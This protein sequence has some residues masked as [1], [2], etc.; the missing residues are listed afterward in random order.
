MIQIRNLHKS[1][2]KLPVLCGINLDLNQP[3]I[4]AILGPNGSGKTTLIKSMLGMVLPSRGEILFKGQ[5]IHGQWA[6]RRHIDYLPQIAR[7]PDNLRVKELLHMIKDI[8]GTSPKAMESL[9]HLF[10]MEAYM[11]KR[12][13]NLSGG[14]RQKANLIQ[15]FMYDSPVVI[16]DE[17]TSGLDPIALLH[18]KELLLAE[19]A[20]GKMILITTHIM[21]FV[22]EMAD[23][24]IFLLD[25]NIH[26]RGSVPELKHTY[27]E[28]NLETAIAGILQGRKPNPLRNGNTTARSHDLNAGLIHLKS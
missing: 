18:L 15:A 5:S 3:G 25:G 26:Y 4:T 10:G 1:F 20:K 12:F 11:D 13:G 28:E 24:V 16:L 22:D 7:F 23:E 8:R 21:S 6:Y 27:Q 19:K 9:I 17:P 2:G 14:T